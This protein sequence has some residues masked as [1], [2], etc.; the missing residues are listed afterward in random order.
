MIYDFAAP[1]WSDTGQHQACLSNILEDGGTWVAAAVEAFVGKGVPRTKLLLGI[2]LSGRVFKGTDVLGKPH[3]E[4]SKMQEG[5]AEARVF[6]AHMLPR[7]GASEHV[8]NH[9]T[10]QVQTRVH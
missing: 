2:P 6:L 4:T 10:L 3:S 9:H 7:P 1:G 8:R 5:Q